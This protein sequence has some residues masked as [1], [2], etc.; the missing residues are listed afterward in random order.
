[1]YEDSL[2]S[3][4]QCSYCLTAKPVCYGLWRDSLCCPFTHLPPVN[5]SAYQASYPLFR[6][7][8]VATTSVCLLLHLTKTLTPL[9]PS[10][11]F[12]SLLPHYYNQSLLIKI[13]SWP[14]IL[15]Q[16]D[17]S[18]VLPYTGW[19]TWLHAQWFLPLKAYQ[20]KLYPTLQKI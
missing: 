15:G 18:L 10:V 12:F 8:W 3:I 11:L 7:V 14:L 16:S 9:L 5:W 20:P 2:F 6:I 17:Q 13:T 1:M 4:S 19:V